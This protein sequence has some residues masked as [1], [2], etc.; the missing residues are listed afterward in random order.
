METR[1]TCN[2]C[3][4]KSSS[5]SHYYYCDNGTWK[6]S[7]NCIKACLGKPSLIT[8]SKLHDEGRYGTFYVDGTGVGS[9]SISQI[10]NSTFA[11]ANGAIIDAGCE[12]GYS[13]PE[14]G[15]TC[16]SC[17]QGSVPSYWGHYY[18][19]DNGTWKYRGSCINTIT[20]RYVWDISLF[21]DYLN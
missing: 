19:C 17:G 16:D 15:G 12:D 7:G 9:P 11:A 13:E 5:W 18:Y 2:D 4:G 1:A 6:Y 10:N 8:G 20:V 14:T 21:L 3:G